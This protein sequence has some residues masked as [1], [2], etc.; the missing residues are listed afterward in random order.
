MANNATVQVLWD[1]KR[2]AQNLVVAGEMMKEWSSI[3]LL[4]PEDYLALWDQA[5]EEV[6][7]IVVLLDQAIGKGRANGN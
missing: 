2:K 4:A 3:D 7:E 6:R 5:A 1:L